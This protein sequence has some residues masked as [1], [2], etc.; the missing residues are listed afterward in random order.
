[1]DDDLK[2]YYDVCSLMKKFIPDRYV[3]GIMPTKVATNKEKRW[4]CAI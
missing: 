4:V 2:M 1:M 3:G